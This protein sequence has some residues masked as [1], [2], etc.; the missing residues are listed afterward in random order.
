MIVI[1]KFF[2][3]MRIKKINV[4]LARKFII[5]GES[6]T[7]N[8]IMVKNLIEYYLKNFANALMK[9]YCCQHNVK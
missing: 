5:R 7:E 3:H 6:L 9:S 8:A 2:L 1:M 4:C